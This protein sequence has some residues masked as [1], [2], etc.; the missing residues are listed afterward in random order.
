[1]QNDI[2]ERL[3]IDPGRRTL[4]ELLQDREAAAHEITTLRS[5]LDRL[6]SHQRCDIRLRESSSAQEQPRSLSPTPGTLLRLTDVCRILALSRST[7]YKRIAEHNFPRP[8]RLGV[9]AVRWRIEAIEVWRDSG[10]TINPD[11]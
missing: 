4:G 5:K 7:I 8:I 9:R 1:M 11:R 3:R 10:A 6:A 2:L